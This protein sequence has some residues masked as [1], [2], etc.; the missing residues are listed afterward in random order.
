MCSFGGDSVLVT[1]SSPF[2]VAEDEA[3]AWTGRPRVPSRRW[4][5]EGRITRHGGGPGRVRH[6]PWELPQK[7]ADDAG[8][9]GHGPPPLPERQA[10]A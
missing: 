2:L 5:H 10:V 6:D 4:A 1:G 8:E 3:A 7:T 9:T